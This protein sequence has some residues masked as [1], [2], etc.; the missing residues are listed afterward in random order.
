MLSECH[1]GPLRGHFGRAKTGS[2]VQRLALWVG[3]DVTVDVNEYM[4]TVTCQ[5]CQHTK[6]EHG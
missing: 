2:R 6:A 4:R 5:T 1:D 3:Q